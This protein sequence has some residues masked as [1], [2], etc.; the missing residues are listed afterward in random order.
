MKPQPFATS[1]EHKARQ[2]GWTA[3]ELRRW[4]HAQSYTDGDIE[5]AFSP[6]ALGGIVQPS[7]AR[8]LPNAA[9]ALGWPVKKLARRV[10][11]DVVNADDVACHVH[12]HEW[13]WGKHKLR[14]YA[15]FLFFA[16]KVVRALANGLLGGAAP[17]IPRAEQE[18]AMLL[19]AFY[20][21]V[22]LPGA[23]AIAP[24][25]LNSQQENLIAFLSGFIREAAVAHEL[26]HIVYTLGRGRSEIIRKL[27]AAFTA[28][29]NPSWGKDWPEEF[30][31]DFLGVKFLKQPAGNELASAH[32][33]MFLLFIIEML[34]QCATKPTAAPG[35]HPPSSARRGLLLTLFPWLADGSALAATDAT[36]QRIVR[37]ACC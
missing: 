6:A 22:P 9:M 3:D 19:R 24:Y 5:A 8:L 32:G 18:A 27:E 33:M 30:T 12:L 21:S 35:S 20:R 14:V 34:E 36:C 15:G 23:W 2:L 37:L 26:G 13:R 29:K 11:L 25:K 7:V 16:N 31:A 28:L 1:L 17:P 10:T 4:L